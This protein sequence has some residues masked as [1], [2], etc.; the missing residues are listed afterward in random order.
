MKQDWEHQVTIN[1]KNEGPAIDW[2]IE[3]GIT[4]V[5]LYLWHQWDRPVAWNI[6]SPRFNQEHEIVDGVTFYFKKTESQ[7]LVMFKLIFG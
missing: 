7:L 2:L 1:P 5:P 3:N 4:L 6:K